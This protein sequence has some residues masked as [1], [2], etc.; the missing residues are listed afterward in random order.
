VKLTY[1]QWKLQVDR[2]V[3]E[4]VGLSADDLPD[5][6]YRDDYDDGVKPATTARRTVAAAKKEFGL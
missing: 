6:R 4:Q 1:E 2:H 3:Q 5:Y